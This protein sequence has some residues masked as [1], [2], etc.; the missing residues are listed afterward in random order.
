MG[1]FDPFQAH[2]IGL[3]DF[4]LHRS[5]VKCAVGEAVDGENH[6]VVGREPIFEA[7]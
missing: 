5:P 4:F 1:V 3:E 2:P 7:L 6:A